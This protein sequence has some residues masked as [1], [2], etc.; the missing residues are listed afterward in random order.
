MGRSGSGRNLAIS[1][2]S[3]ATHTSREEGDTSPP[4][5]HSSHED[6]PR[7]APDLP[8]SDAIPPARK[9]VVFRGSAFAPVG[10]AGVAEEEP[11][12]VRPVGTST[13]G[14]AGPVVALE[15]AV[16]AP[17]STGT[18]IPLGFTGTVSPTDTIHSRSRTTP[19]A[20]TGPLPSAGAPHTAANLASA[21]SFAKKGG[22]IPT[23]KLT[24][25]SA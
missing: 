25:E 14:A 17:A 11:P 23:K 6:S 8:P 24:E 5:H 7:D 10:L 20:N 13:K 4:P 2:F 15:R 1:S 21:L 3:P 22:R 19:A 18:D 16:F 9:P 12:M